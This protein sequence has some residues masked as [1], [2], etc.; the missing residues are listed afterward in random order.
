MALILGVAKTKANSDLRAVRTE[1][2]Q[3]RASCEEF[4]HC[5]LNDMRMKSKTP[6]S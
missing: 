5:T 4:L 1:D 3:L 2:E 6:K